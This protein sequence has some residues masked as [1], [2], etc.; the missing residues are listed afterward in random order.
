MKTSLLALLLVTC[1]TSGAQKLIRTDYPWITIAQI[2]TCQADTFRIKA[3]VTEVY[4]CP[5][6]PPG[7]QCK[8]CIGDHLVVKD[9]DI[10]PGAQTRVF[11]EK[12]DQ[13]KNHAVYVFTLTHHNK[14]HPEFGANLVHAET[15]KK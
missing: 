12:P 2:D 15:L 3:Q 1:I 4:H 9:S 6:C 10:S 11:V 5:P 7:A 13:F 8:P 14:F